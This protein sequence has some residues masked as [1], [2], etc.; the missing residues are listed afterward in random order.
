MP[1]S[2]QTAQS[3]DRLQIERLQNQTEWFF[4]VFDSTWCD[5]V[6]TNKTPRT[7]SIKAVFNLQQQ[8]HI[9]KKFNF[10]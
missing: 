8:I 10:D 3:M 5:N 4:A 6:Q 7:V 2:V 9:D 1:D